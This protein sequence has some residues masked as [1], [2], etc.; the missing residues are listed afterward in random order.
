MFLNI[1]SN[2]LKGHKLGWVGKTWEEFGE[3]AE[4]IFLEKGSD[5]PKV[6]F[7]PFRGIFKFLNE[8]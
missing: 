7:F 3:E 4:Y 5:N 6:I 2:F 8:F 1:K